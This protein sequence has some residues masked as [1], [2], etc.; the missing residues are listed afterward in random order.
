MKFEIY[1]I[2]CERFGDIIESDN[3]YAL[4]LFK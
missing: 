2:L 4:R 3:M 1:T